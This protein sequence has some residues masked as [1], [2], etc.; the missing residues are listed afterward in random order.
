MENEIK[1]NAIIVRYGEISLKGKN[2]RSFELKLKT[3]I[4]NFLKVH[5]INFTSVILRRGRIYIR[6]IAALPEL[7]KVLG[8]HSYSPVLEIEKDI[9][10]MEK[11]VFLFVPMIAAA[12]NFR[13]SCQRVD[14]RFP[15]KSIDIEQKIGHMLH[16]KTGTPVKLKDPELEF[17]IEIGEDGIF[18][19]AKKIRGHS[20]MPYGTAGKLV[21][22]I[23]GGIDSPV[24][25]FLMMKRGVQPILLHFKLSDEDAE[26][27][28]KIKEKLAEYAAGREIKLYIIS[29]DEIFKGKFKELYDNER[30]ARYLCIICKH[31]MHKKA[32]EIARKEGALGIITG[33][34]LAQVASQTLKNL[35]AYRLISEFPVYSPLISFEKEHTVKIAREIGTFDLSILKTPGCTPPKNPKTGVSLHIFNK[36]LKELDL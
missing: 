32:G 24:A 19:F 2:R 11:E 6:G 29:R 9:E 14:K 10:V 1:F 20:G 17:H 21:S 8:I 22:L 27:V 36:I 15:G 16:I 35:L 4:I 25:T 30:Y 26:K 3:D 28:V 7:E 31:L 13:V 33:D 12:K 23:S 5:K 18:L 34:N